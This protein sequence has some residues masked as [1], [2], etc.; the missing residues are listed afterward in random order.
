MSSLSIS[1]L[2]VTQTVPAKL[3][4][5]NTERQPLTLESYF[6][7][8]QLALALAIQKSRPEHLT[9]AEF[10]Q[11]LQKH[12]KLGNPNPNDELRYVDSVEFW[13][14]QYTQIRRQNQVLEEKIH[15]LE[16]LQGL[17]L[18]EKTEGLTSVTMQQQIWELFKGIE[19]KKNLDPETLSTSQQGLSWSEHHG[20]EGSF[21]DDQ[22]L[23]L[24]ACVLRMVREQAKLEKAMA[25][26]G[27]LN[28]INT[29]AGQTSQLLKSIDQIVSSSC[30]PHQLMKTSNKSSQIS[31]LILRIMNQVAMSFLSCFKALNLLSG[32]PPGRT[33]KDKIVYQMVMFFNRSLD[34]LHAMSLTQT[35]HEAAHGHDCSRPSTY[36]VDEEYIVNRSLVNC[37]VLILKSLDWKADV[38]GH[39]DLLEGILC[40]V[41]KHTGRLVSEAIFLEHVATSDNPGNMTQDSPVLTSQKPS[42]FESRYVVQILHAALGGT[43]KKLRIAEVLAARKDQTSRPDATHSFLSSNRSLSHALLLLQSTLVKSAVGGNHLESF[44]MPT[45]PAEE[46]QTAV[47]ENSSVERYGSEWLLEN[48]WTLVGWDLVA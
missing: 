19:P 8:S 43:S 12:I 35:E 36:V 38:A 13:K 24:C 39:S 1:T 23:K 44:R 45:P 11:Q 14:D 18:Q 4:S 34:S 6:S 30:H 17:C 41:L 3:N 47:D 28:Q 27:S 15:H 7:R 10:C 2:E 48:V 20:D 42:A 33:R 21:D 9:T 25:N 22:V 5:P 29:L 32:T 26:T 37:L 31:S 46:P 40:S 16:N